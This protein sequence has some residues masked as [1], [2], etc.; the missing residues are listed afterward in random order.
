MPQHK[1][2]LIFKILHQAKL[3]FVRIEFQ[4]PPRKEINTWRSCFIPNEIFESHRVIML[5]LHHQMIY[6]F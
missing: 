4:A 6:L 5:D 2:E 3:S 1:N